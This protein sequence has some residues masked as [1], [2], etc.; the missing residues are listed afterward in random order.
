MHGQGDLDIDQLGRA[1]QVDLARRQ[2]RT[3]QLRSG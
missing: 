3:G 1:D 2:A